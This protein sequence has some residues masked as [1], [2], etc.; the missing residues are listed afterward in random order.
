MT[1]NKMRPTPEDKVRKRQAKVE[2]RLEE[3]LEKGLE[4]T[5]PASDPVAVTQPPKS[6]PD[7]KEP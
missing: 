3:S 6:R 1:A 7:R 5:F 2:E 4:D